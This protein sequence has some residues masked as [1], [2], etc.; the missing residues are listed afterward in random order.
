MIEVVRTSALIRDE[1]T[2]MADLLAGIEMIKDDWSSLAGKVKKEY[3]ARLGIAISEWRKSSSRRS[4][5]KAM[6]KTAWAIDHLTDVRRTLMGWSLLGESSGEINR[7]DREARGVFGGR[8]LH[9]LEHMKDDRIKTGADLI[10][11]AARG[12]LR[13]GAGKW[14]QRHSPCHAVLFEDLMRYRMKTDRP[15]RENSQL[16][17]W[18]H[19]QIPDLVK[20][21]G[22]L[23]GIHT[24]DTGA[25][26]SSRYGAGSMTPGIRCRALTAA[27]LTDEFMK[28]LIEEDNPGFDWTRARPGM[29]VPFSGGELLAVPTTNGVLKIHADINA[30]QTLQ[31]RFW[32]RHAD[33][34]R[35][36]CQKAKKDGKDIWVPKALGKRLAGALGGSGWLV[37]TGH[38]SGSCRWEKAKGRVKK[39][40]LAQEGALTE[41]EASM[42][43]GLEEELLEMSGEVTVFFRDPSGMVLP[44]DLW[45]PAK[46]FWS[47]VK[48]KT[49]SA[50]FA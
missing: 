42:L 36:P 28:G 14:E 41:D 46:T 19:R 6:G 11:Q 5:G 17:L 50:L 4:A 22:E 13:E 3:R 2:L 12:Y 26:F 25:A 7:Q 18:S 35:L 27:D 29:L 47:I 45:Y 33:A 23:Y 49:R 32:T 24:C 30:A 20:M 15:R 38:E 40:A 9:H 44:A 1:G 10:V 37:P 43:N 39:E 31:R 8:L 34:F 21:Q 16:M 48:A